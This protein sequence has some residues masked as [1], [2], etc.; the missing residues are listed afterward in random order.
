MDA[1]RITAVALDEDFHLRMMALEWRQA[2]R[3]DNPSSSCCDYTVAEHEQDTG[4]EGRPEL[5][6][7]CVC[8]R[9]ADLEED[10]Y[11]NESLEVRKEQLVTKTVE[12]SAGTRV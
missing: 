7:H 11:F 1:D 3:P 2:R 10:E 9:Y 12:T 5:G 8:K 6:G 4:L